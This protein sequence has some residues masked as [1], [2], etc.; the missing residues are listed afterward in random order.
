[1]ESLARLATE[2]LKNLDP[3]PLIILIISSGLD[4][5]TPVVA[6]SSH[7]DITLWR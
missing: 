2:N 6:S 1:M 4:T 3:T 5:G 7:S